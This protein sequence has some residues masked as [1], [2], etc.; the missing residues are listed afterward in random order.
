MP[1]HAGVQVATAAPLTRCPRFSLLSWVGIGLSGCTPAAAAILTGKLPDLDTRNGPFRQAVQSR[2]PSPVPG[3]RPQAKRT[4]FGEFAT[5]F[6][7]GQEAFYPPGYPLAKGC[8]I[9]PVT[10]TIIAAHIL[11]PTVAYPGTLKN[12]PGR[13]FWST[14]EPWSL[15]H[16]LLSTGRSV[17]PGATLKLSPLF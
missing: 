1:S 5:R 7:N 12:G 17:L 16:V 9:H 11:F 8:S 3:S 15:V 2:S 14:F 13:L 10:C 4:W 6:R